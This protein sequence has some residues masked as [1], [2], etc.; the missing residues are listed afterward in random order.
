MRAAR[1][2]VWP[3]A[4]AVGDFWGVSDRT[5]NDEERGQVVQLA[6]AVP[7]ILLAGRPWAG[8]GVAGRWASSR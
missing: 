8:E 7:T 6:E 1:W 4:V 2:T 3:G 5:L